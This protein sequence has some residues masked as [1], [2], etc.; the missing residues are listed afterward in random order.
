MARLVPAALETVNVYERKCRKKKNLRQQ[1]LR[2]KLK[3]VRYF[4]SNNG[5]IVLRLF[6]ISI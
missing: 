1:V 6:E 2:E 5:V 3:C 4:V